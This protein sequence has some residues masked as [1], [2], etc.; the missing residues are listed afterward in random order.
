MSLEYSYSLLNQPEQ[1]AAL[2]QLNQEIWDVRDRLAAMMA[3]R[4]VLM[5][6]MKGEVIDERIE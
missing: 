5:N 4:A 1:V 6:L 2:E 3:G